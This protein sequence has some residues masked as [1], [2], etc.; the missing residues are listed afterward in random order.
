MLLGRPVLWGLTLG[1]QCGVEAVLRS[2]HAEL[3]LA[4][5]RSLELSTS[6]L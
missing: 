1:G 6:L 3:E 4:M 5:V 2:L